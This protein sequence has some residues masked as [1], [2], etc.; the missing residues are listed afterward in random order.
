MYAVNEIV[1]DKLKVKPLKA[2][3][4]REFV[5]LMAGFVDLSMNGGQPVTPSGYSLAS[6]DQI[7][8]PFD[9]N[10]PIKSIFHVTSYRTIREPGKPLIYDPIFGNCRFDRTGRIT[11]THENNGLYA[12]L[13]LHNK[14]RDNKNRL[15]KYA[16]VF[17]EVDE[18][19]DELVLRRLFEY[20]I[21]AGNLLLQ[22][23]E[24]AITSVVK[25]VN[26]SKSLGISLDINKDADYLRG[27]LQ[28]VVDKH[29]ALF[30]E[31]SGDQRA[32]FKILIESAVK[33]EVLKFNDAEDVREWSWVRA[34]K[35]KG[36]KKLVKIDVGNK[37][38]EGLI[39]FMLSTGKEAKEELLRRRSEYYQ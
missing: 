7:Q 35:E 16:A 2:G 5:L 36:T 15:P 12:Y 24:E 26:A 3:E 22:M 11:V 38:I 10:H 37:P 29:P 39:D 1:S 17:Y 30:I 4:H 27:K 13:K 34:V 31:L 25:K 33:A 18:A 8:D 6:E 20:K 23:E 21:A 9:E 19:R 28:P 32:F 14:N